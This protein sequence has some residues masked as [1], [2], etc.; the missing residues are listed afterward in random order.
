[1]G[2]RESDS[3]VNDPTLCPP[4]RTKDVPPTD[5][6]AATRPPAHRPII[7]AEKSLYKSESRPWG[8]DVVF[9]GALEVD[10]FLKSSFPED[11]VLILKIK[12]RPGGDT[13][14]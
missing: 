2:F 11:E 8:E 10:E 13:D 5:K 7:Q 14:Y 3:R 9:M 12:K 1:M 6:G 4:R